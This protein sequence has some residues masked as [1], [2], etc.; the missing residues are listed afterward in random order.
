MNTSS[1]V[2][3]FAHRSITVHELEQMIEDICGKGKEDLV[4]KLMKMLD[5]DESLDISYT[6]FMKVEKRAATV[7]APCFRLQREL[8]G[9]CMGKR[10]FR[11]KKKR[12]KKMLAAEFC[13]R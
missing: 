4:N 2:T 3:R 7:L 5:G 1:L 12:L 6:E 13:E 11:K 8:Q 10:F 9:K